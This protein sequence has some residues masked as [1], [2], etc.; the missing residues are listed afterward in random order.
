MIYV[1]GGGTG[2]E[3]KSLGGRHTWS[4]DPSKDSLFMSLGK[5]LNLSVS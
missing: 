1:I 2:T 3:H 5:L 4:F